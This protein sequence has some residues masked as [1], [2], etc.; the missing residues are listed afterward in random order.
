MRIIKRR[1]FIGL[2]IAMVL[3]SSCQ[4]QAATQ[5]ETPI[6]SVGIPIQTET[7]RVWATI[8]SDSVATP[9][10]NPTARPI[11]AQLQGR[12]AFHSDRDGSLEIY[13]MNADG[14]TV[15]RLT[16][17]PAVDVF[18]AWS[19]DGDKIAFTSDRDGYP[20]IFIVDADGTNL[21]KLTNTTSSDALPAWSPDG[22]QIVF[23]SDRDGNDEI[24]SVRING[25]D[26]NRLTNDPGQDLFPN[27][28]PDG[29]WIVFT[30]TRDVN[31]EIYKMRTDGSEMVRLTDE[32][33]VDAN[34]VWS[35]DGTRIA[36]S[37]R[38][39]GFTN[40]FVMNADGTGQ[41]Q[42]T[43]YKSV[44]EVPSWSPDG[45]MIA[46]ASDIEGNREIFVISAD[47]ASINRLTDNLQED[48][49]PSWSPQLN[50]LDA[51]INEPTPAPEGVCIN[52]ADGLYGF[53]PDNPIRI[54]F[55]PREEGTDESACLPWLLGP[56][57]QQIETTLIDEVRNNGAKLCK[58]SITYE[59]QT[60]DGDIM[61]FDVFNFE[62][63]KA[64]QGYSCG[65][66][67]EYLKAITSARY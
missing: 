25:G 62:Q 49:Y 64:P 33:A 5:I 11:S 28:S 31:S 46:F 29:E 41:T 8:A 37:S 3:I 45:Q 53:S 7:V 51:P 9:S 1:V 19:H 61:Y 52:S 20:D 43:F 55:D 66:P 34:P 13:V 44:V 47:G 38:R 35:P 32:P 54:G 59:G 42:L 60:S 6:E 65:S 4:N 10:P 14:S 63:P 56:G 50:Y 15:S 26:P 57:G 27:W 21:T 23:V 40:L 58:V 36:F 48:F 39:D 12:I 2:L 16:N 67:I 18:P 22:S 30:S 24:Y 17:D